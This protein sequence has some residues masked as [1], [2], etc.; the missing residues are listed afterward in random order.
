MAVTSGAYNY[1]TTRD[2]IILR[3]LRIIGAIGQGETAAQN[4]TA[5]TEAA[6]ALN[7]LCKEWEADG[8][9]LWA[10]SKW[11]VIPTESLSTY[12]IVNGPLKVIQAWRHLTDSD[13]D[14]PLL[15]I[16]RQEYQLLGSKTSE[17]SPSQVW[18]DP[19]GNYSHPGIATFYVTPDLNA[20]TNETYILVGQK[21]FENFNA[22]TDLPDFPQ[23]WYNAIKW[24]LADQLSYEYGVGLSERSMI[25]KKAL[26]HKEQALSFGTEEGSYKIQP[27]VLG[28]FK[29][30]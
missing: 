29:V 8:M 30:K 13:T 22:S 15:V 11:P 6:E 9:P 21:P 28:V 24:G 20:Q 27:Q 1:S 3:S 17:G 26:Y 19:P 10:I 4:A 16:T 12:L 7:D 18:Y 2:A 5:V 25:T 23:Y 14:S